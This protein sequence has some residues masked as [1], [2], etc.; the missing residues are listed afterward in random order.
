MQVSEQTPN[1]AVYHHELPTKT[2][3]F[4]AAVALIRLDDT[5]P[6]EEAAAPHGLSD[7][8]RYTVVEATHQP[9]TS[10]KTRCIRYSL[11]LIDA[12]APNS[13]TA[14]LRFLERGLVCAHP[15]IPGAAVRASF[16]ERGLPEEMDPRLWDDLEGFL[17]G[18]QL[19]SA[20]GV[21]AA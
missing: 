9:D 16:S 2:H 21:P 7:P 4:V 13:P 17:S 6:F 12:K 11:E 19:E 18:V 10:R 5:A 8:A 3:T 15:S 14:P 20:P 1:A